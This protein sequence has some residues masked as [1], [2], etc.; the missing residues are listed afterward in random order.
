MSEVKTYNPAKVNVII[1]RSFV[2]GFADDSFIQ[3][4]KDEDNYEVYVGSQGEVSRSKKLHPVGRFTVTLKQTSP[5]NEKL[6]KLAKSDRMFPAYVV[7]RN[8]QGAIIGGNYG[9][10]EKDADYERSNEVEEVE[11]TIVV[12]DYEQNLVN[13]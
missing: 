2:T 8:T 13:N 12:G 6:S 7:D 9:W 1:D 4:E 3:T 11:W 5:F 10:I